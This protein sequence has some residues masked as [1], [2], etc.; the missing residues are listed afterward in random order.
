D[1]AKDLIRYDLP[2]TVHFL[3]SNYEEVGF[4]GNAG[5]PEDVVEYIAVDMGALGDGQHSDEYTVSICAKDSSGPY[6][7]GLRRKFT[8]LCKAHE[9]PYKVD[10]YPYY[11]SDASAAIRAGYDVR[12]ALIGPGIE[13]SHSYERTH[14]SSMEATRELLNRYVQ[15]TMEEEA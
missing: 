15:S 6:D 10:I 11:G 13:S 3:I 14:L 9:I 4:G 7:I 1:L 8:A 12:H 2:H 5:I